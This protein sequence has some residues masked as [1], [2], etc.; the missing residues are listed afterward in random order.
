MCFEGLGKRLVKEML[1]SKDSRGVG[2][3]KKE[4]FP[5]EKNQDAKTCT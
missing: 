3:A 5:K 2:S 4:L 1:I